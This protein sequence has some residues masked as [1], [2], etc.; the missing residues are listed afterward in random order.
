MILLGFD[1]G[2]FTGS[3]DFSLCRCA[4]HVFVSSQCAT[5]YTHKINKKIHNFIVTLSSYKVRNMK[6]NIG[7]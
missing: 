5:F 1:E 4:A 3:V 7:I 6:T 2:K